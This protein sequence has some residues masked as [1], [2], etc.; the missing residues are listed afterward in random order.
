VDVTQPGV[1]PQSVL[2]LC[3]HNIVRS[4]MAAA[5]ARHFFGGSLRIAEA[6]VRAG[7][8]DPFVVAAMEE[9]GIDLKHHKP[10]LL[11]ELED[12]EGLDFDL[13]VSLSPEAHHR[14]LEL[15]R[16]RPVQVE[17]WA[18]PNPSA[19]WGNREQRLD[20][21]RAVRDELLQRIRSRFGAATASGG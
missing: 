3:A 21:Y 6:G 15:T 18:I 5:L 16:A 4:P 1:R 14:A 11:D 12:L 9:V 19:V 13:V 10:M 7:E 2:F 20:A 17:Y 8:P